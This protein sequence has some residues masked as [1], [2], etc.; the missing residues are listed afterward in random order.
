MAAYSLILAIL[1][2]SILSDIYKT[3]FKYHLESRVRAIGL[4][5]A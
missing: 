3:I 4:S 1:F 5:K 2:L